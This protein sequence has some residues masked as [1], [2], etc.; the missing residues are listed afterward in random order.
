MSRFDDPSSPP[1]DTR[2]VPGHPLH[3]GRDGTIWIYKRNYRKWA[4][5]KPR[6]KD[7]RAQVQ[8]R[9]GSGKR[10]YL[11]VPRLVLSAWGQ[12]RPI[13][14][15][16]VHFP[17]PN[18]MNNHLDNLRWGPKNAHLVG[19]RLARPAEPMRG[20]AHPLS[21]FDE[22]E[23]PDIRRLYRDGFSAQE[24]AEKYGVRQ[25]TV[26]R[27]LRGE[28]YAH[29]P[30]PDGPIV[31]RPARI[32]HPWQSAPSKLTWGKVRKIRRLAARTPRPTN[33]ELAAKF[34]VSV[35]T[36]SLIVNNRSWIE[37]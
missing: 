31:M 36:I 32:Q 25:M 22:A 19:R 11:T 30:D 35:T 13:G 14:T 12:P 27:I 17:D 21:R 15:Q 9:D 1:P 7:G 4:A 10:A 37:S 29:V 5:L 2:P 24:I 8:Y 33:G 28:R 18:Y 34:G 6:D 16:V 23:I 20:S 3:A 26:L